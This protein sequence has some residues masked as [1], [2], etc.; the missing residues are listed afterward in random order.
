MFGTAIG[1][2]FKLKKYPKLKWTLT[3]ITSLLVI[4]VVFGIWFLS[5]LP[6]EEMEEKR[7]IQE[8]SSVENISYLSENV[9]VQSSNMPVFTWQD[10][11]FDDTKIYFHVVSNAND[12]L[13]SGTYTFEKRFQYYKLDNVVLNITEEIPPILETGEGYD[14]ALLA[15]SEDNWVN[16]FSTVPFNIP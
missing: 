8:T 9:M 15:V 11:V 3:S 7:K 5:L 14:F 2:V 16:L 10:G 13:L 6:K 12:D 4:F 1:A